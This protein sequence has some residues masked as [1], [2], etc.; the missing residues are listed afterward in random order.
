MLMLIRCSCLGP[1]QL[2]VCSTV[3]QQVLCSGRPPALCFLHGVLESF[4]SCVAVSDHPL[5][6]KDQS[7]VIIIGPPEPVLQLRTLVT[8]F[9]MLNHAL[10]TRSALSARSVG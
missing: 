10:W 3:S 2:L 1:G 8:R 5:L 6:L 4:G 9:H 7:D